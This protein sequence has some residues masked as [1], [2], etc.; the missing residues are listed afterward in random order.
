MVVQLV[1]GKP[2]AEQSVGST[3][4]GNTEDT[5]A[6]IMSMESI[7]RRVNQHKYMT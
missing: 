6:I 3:L 1:V 4:E 2:I 7:N 5:P